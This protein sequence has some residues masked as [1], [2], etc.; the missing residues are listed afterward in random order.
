LT[1]ARCHSVIAEGHGLNRHWMR[2]AQIF[3]RR[4]NVM[5]RTVQATSR[6]RGPTPLDAPIIAGTRDKAVSTIGLNPMMKFNAHSRVDGD[7]KVT[8]SAWFASDV[9]LPGL[10]HAAVVTGHIA[11][12]RIIRFELADARSIARTPSG[13]VRL[14]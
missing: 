9:A 11:R 6:V 7:A 10:V 13:A 12:G 2:G 8:G 4:P 14:R 5:V 3:M 1:T